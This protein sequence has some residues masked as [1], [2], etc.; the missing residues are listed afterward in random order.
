M[1][2]MKSNLAY[3]ESDDGVNFVKPDLH[4]YA[5][6]NDYNNNLIKNVHG[7]CV[8]YDK[9][10]DISQRYKLIW[11]QYNREKPF[12][13]G[14]R[15][16]VLYLQTEFTGMILKNLFSIILLILRTYWNTMKIQNS[17]LYILASVWITLFREDLFLIKE[18]YFFLILTSR[19]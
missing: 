18:Q 15:Y 19:S 16:M 17:I 1:D 11:V 5:I 3:A 12:F 14:A 4:I 7:T 6:H 10:A 13:Q 2:D 8:L 9:H